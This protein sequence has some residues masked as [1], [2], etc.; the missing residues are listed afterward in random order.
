MLPEGIQELFFDI[1]RGN[2]EKVESDSE[3]SQVVDFHDDF[4]YSRSSLNK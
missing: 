1:L 3:L 2:G 4:R